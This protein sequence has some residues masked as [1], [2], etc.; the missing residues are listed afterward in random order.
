M[1]V[2]MFLKLKDIPGESTDSKHKDTIDIQSWSWG[3][4][5][6]GNMHFGGGGGAGKVNIQDIS[7]VK[8]QDKASPKLFQACANGKHL[9]DATLI[10]RKAGEKPVEYLTIKLYDLI[11]SSYNTGGSGSEDRLME[12]VSLNFSKVEIDYKMQDAKGAAAGSVMAKYD[13]KQNKE[14]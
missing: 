6:T 5:Q 3:A 1:A 7:I 11:V 14:Y 4:T 2:D 9:A 8:F 13:I 10:C 12:T